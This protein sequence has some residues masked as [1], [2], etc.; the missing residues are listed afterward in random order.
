VHPFYYEQD[1]DVASCLYEVVTGFKDAR[2]TVVQDREIR[3]RHV[4]ISAIAPAMGSVA[5]IA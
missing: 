3:P 4:P 2:V 5:V 1:P